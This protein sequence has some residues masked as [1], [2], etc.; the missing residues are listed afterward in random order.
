MGGGEEEDVG[1]LLYNI[2]QAAIGKPKKDAAKDYT[3]FVDMKA[4][5]AGSSAGLLAGHKRWEEAMGETRYSGWCD[6][7]AILDSAEVVF[8]RLRTRTGIWGTGF[9]RYLGSPMSSK[10]KIDTMRCHF[11]K[12]GRMPI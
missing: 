12:I 6:D 1:V 2:W 11:I 4:I 10:L 9:N 5:P 8:Q 7:D 3:D